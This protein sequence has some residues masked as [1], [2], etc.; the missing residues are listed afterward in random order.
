MPS[1]KRGLFPP[2]KLNT[3]GHMSIN[4]GLL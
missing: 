1:M 4:A 2:Y 3:I